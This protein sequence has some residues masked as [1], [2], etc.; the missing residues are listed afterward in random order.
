MLCM[1]WLSNL[2]CIST[3]KLYKVHSKTP[4]AE[5][6]SLNVVCQIETPGNFPNS[7]S[8]SFFVRSYFRLENLAF[9][10][11]YR[12]FLFRLN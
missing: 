3:I 12:K 8:F 9:S 1:N 10:D 5:P 2:L 6:F 4:L 7:F 11:K